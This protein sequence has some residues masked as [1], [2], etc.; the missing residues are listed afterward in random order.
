M[1][2]WLNADLFVEGLREAGPQFDRQKVVDAINAMTAYTADGVIFGVNWTKAHVERDNPTLGCDF[3]T[4]IEDSEFVPAYSESG[5]P[6]HCVDGS[7]PAN[8]TTS[9]EA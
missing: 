1:A 3:K 9:Y 2:G 5:K 8:L 6:F 7:D 4:L